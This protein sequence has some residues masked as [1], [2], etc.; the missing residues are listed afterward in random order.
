MTAILYNFAEEMN[1]QYDK[2]KVPLEYVIRSE[3]LEL[4][5]DPNSKEDVLQY[6]ADCH[7]DLEDE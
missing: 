6:W 5:Y 3:M 7:G 4:G 2:G 1:K